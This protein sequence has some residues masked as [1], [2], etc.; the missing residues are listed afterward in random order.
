MPTYG[1]A[2]IAL[3]R[4]VRTTPLGI[5]EK[6]DSSKI[7]TRRF[8]K[9]QQHASNSQSTPSSGAQHQNHFGMLGKLLAR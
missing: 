2:E 5:L 7:A 9:P 1:Q 8:Q 4:Q 6:D 3:P